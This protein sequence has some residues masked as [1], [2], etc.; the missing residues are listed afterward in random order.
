MI[1]R[2]C[3]VMLALIA[4]GETRGRSQT[5]NSVANADLGKIAAAA[6][7][8]T[9]FHVAPAG[10][11]VTKLSGNGA[12]V[13]PG[14]GNIFVTVSCG[15]SGFCDNQNMLV[16]IG[17][18]GTP[19]NRAYALEN[20]TVS[21]SG[22]SATIATTPTTGNSISF[23]VGPIGRNSSKTF[24]IGYD[25]VVKGDSSGASSGNS[26]ASLSVTI[27]R[28]NGN[29]PSTLSGTVSAS[30]F[31][32]L[33]AGATQAMS[34]GMISRPRAGPGLVTLAPGATSVVTS[35]DGVSP[36]PGSTATSAVVGVTGEGGQSVSVSVPT[37]FTMYGPGGSTIEVTPDPDISGS[38]TLSGSLGSAGS[39]TVTIGGSFP[40]STGTATG[41]Y[42]GS[43]P[44]IFQYN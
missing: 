38:V 41:A 10:G 1:L 42:A 14:T 25:F 36:R 19:T 27:S 32:T 18:T 16:A 29:S 35:G 15:N 28:T 39:T 4:F 44:V 43:F 3:L 23:Q 2:W 22:A 31:R 34:F 26:A 11:L 24:Y 7:G 33:V 12:R 9:R 8:D 13:S 20:F 40:L 17:Q 30:V 37:S 5:V 21:T 6:A